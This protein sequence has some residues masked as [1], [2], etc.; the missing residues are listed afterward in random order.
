MTLNDAPDPSV[1]EIS[2]FGPGLGEAIAIHF[3]SGNWITVDS[4]KDPVSERSVTLEYFERI[5]I[6]CSHAVKLVVSTHG[7]DDHIGGLADLLEACS[8]ARFACP[9][10]MTKD[11]FFSLLAVDA[12]LERLR[13]SV[14]G[15]FRRINT[16]LDERRNEPNR[17]GRYM[18]A[19]EGRRL[20]EAAATESSP[21]VIV[22]ALTPS[23]TALTRSL[24]KLARMYPE[25][26]GKQPLSDLP[27]EV[28]L[29]LW[30][31][32][33]DARILLGSDV[34]SGT[35]DCG[36]NGVLAW[37]EHPT[38]RAQ[39]FKVAHHGGRSGHHPDVWGEL[40]IRKPISVLTPF[41]RGRHSLPGDDDLQRITGLSSRTLI[42]ALPRPPQPKGEVRQAAAALGGIVSDVQIQAQRIGHVRLRREI[43]DG[44]TWRCDVD[45]PACEVTRRSS[46]PR[47]IRNRSK[48]R[49]ERKRPGQ[50]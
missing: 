21:P 25:A 2:L 3:G 35:T 29:S 38:T 12:R 39:V 6:D 44:S 30:I 28:A 10:A 5:G 50:G 31:E 14:F 16:L 9:S 41:V 19:Y 33:G 32:V 36:W 47:Q 40:L 27:N 15:E 18:Y 48:R 1:I 11:Q 43:A 46:A 34:E 26:D 23:D 22:M 20:F 7:H 49:A 37:P 45:P 17:L 24:E 4:C 13:R 8:S 42:T